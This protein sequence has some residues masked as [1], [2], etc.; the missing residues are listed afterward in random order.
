MSVVEE[1]SQSVNW[2]KMPCNHKIPGRNLG[3]EYLKVC[4]ELDE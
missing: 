2:T 4:E 3:Y 1:T